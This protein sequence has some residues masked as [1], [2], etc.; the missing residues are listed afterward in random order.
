MNVNIETADNLRRKLTI[1]V[2]PD[3]IKRELDR[4]F[5]ELKRGV[6]LKG[7][8]PGRA[9]RKLLERFF[10]DQVRGEVIQKLVKEYTDKALAENDLKPV[11]PPEIVTEETD[12]EKSLKFSATFD[13]RP[14]I[15]VKDYEGLKVPDAKVE[16]T[17]EQV[18]EAIER[19]RERQ[20][21]LK[22]V[23]DRTIV[24]EGDYALATVEAFENDQPLSSVKSED[25]LIEVSRRSLAHGV[26]EALIG[27]E[28]GVETKTTRTYEADYTQKELAGKTVEWRALAKEIYRR[29]LPAID[30]DFAKD[31]GE[32]SLEAFRAKVRE[33]LL[34]HAKQ[35]ADLRVRQ[36]LLDLVIERNP[37][38]LPESL[39][40]REVNAMEA[41]LHS[42]L[43]SGG[44][45]HEDATERVKQSADDLKSRA[46]KRARTTLIVDALAEQEK[47][48]ID[49]DALASKVAEI[50]NASG[51]NRDKA[52]EFYRNEENLEGLRQT[53]R[54]EKA[55]DL[56]LERAKREEVSPAASEAPASGAAAPEKDREEPA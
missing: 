27:A 26:D 56:I 20:A 4:A 48:E 33:Q 49:D 52:A 16:V 50:V 10:G 15:E 18:D 21:T 14:Q 22:K 53:M 39:V 19:F 11:V 1:E 25:R 44:L 5:N 24:E 6:V 3:E 47:I 43:E 28:I 46:E 37:I 13:L 29:E 51:R 40:A 17:D 41:E 42:T 31:Q 36:G 30:E 38:E 2:E 23:E 35:E 34:A 9:P 55:L 12:L 45:S 8:R 7:F 54:R 32:E